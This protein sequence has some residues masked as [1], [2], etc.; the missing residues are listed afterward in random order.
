MPIHAIAQVIDRWLATASAIISAH[1]I[2]PTRCASVSAAYAADPA[3]MIQ[4]CVPRAA[5]RRPAH[6]VG[7]PSRSA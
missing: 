1:P 2:P 4:F 3:Q 7:L 6:L 5:G